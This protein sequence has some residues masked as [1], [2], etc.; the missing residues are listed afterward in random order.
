MALGY[1][2]YELGVQDFPEFP[3]IEHS[4]YARRN[5]RV[6]SSYK[7]LGKYKKANYILEQQL[8]PIIKPRPV[9]PIVSVPADPPTIVAGPRPVSRMGPYENLPMPIG[10]PLAPDPIDPGFGG[11]G[12]YENLP[13]PIESSRRRYSGRSSSLDPGFDGSGGF[14]KLPMPIESYS[15]RSLFP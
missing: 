8:I 4:P 6:V 15:G 5:F 2:A 3:D 14:Q 10:Q 11:G 13:M 9:A 12:G 7:P 1:K